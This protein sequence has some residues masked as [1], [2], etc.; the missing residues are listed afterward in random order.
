MRSCWRGA[1]GFA[2]CGAVASGRVPGWRLGQSLGGGAGACAAARSPGWRGR[3]ADM[4]IGGGGSEQ[5]GSEH[6]GHASTIDHAAR[7]M[8]PGPA[9]SVQGSLSR[10]KTAIS[11]PAHT[12]SSGSVISAVWPGSQ[13]CTSSIANTAPAPR[14]VAAKADRPAWNS[15]Q[16]RAP[17]VKHAQE[18]VGEVRRAVLHEGLAERQQ[19][20]AVR[21][22]LEVE[23]REPLPGDEREERDGEKRGRPR[24]R[25]PGERSREEQRRGHAGELRPSRGR[26]PRTGC[27]PRGP[28]PSRRLQAASRVRARGVRR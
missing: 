24:A 25:E 13:V 23:G 14:P 15:S 9:H 12:A 3:L 20:E 21:R 27:V 1:A 6:R 10:S 18:H 17:F 5:Q 7:G 8:F 16:T 2:C 26:G 28:R 11:P 22:E 4:T 19:R